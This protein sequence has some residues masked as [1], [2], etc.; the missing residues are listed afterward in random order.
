MNRLAEARSR[1]LRRRILHKMTVIK[2]RGLSSTAVGVFTE[3]AHTRT[4][5]RI[6]RT[7]CV[8]VPE[9]D[10]GECMGM[11]VV[12]VDVDGLHTPHETAKEAGDVY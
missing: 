6:S 10:C 4:S 8:I 11:Y 3:T 7:H 12:R 5:V 2:F 1:K 9:H